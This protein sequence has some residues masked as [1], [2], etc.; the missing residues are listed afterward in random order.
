[1]RYRVAAALLFCVALSRVGAQN[2]TA[3]LVG[4]VT[5]PSGSVVAGAK[6]EIRN[7]ATNQVR[8]VQSDHKGEFT[9]PNLVA[10][11][12]E[13]TVHKEGFRTLR[14]TDLEL[15]LHQEARLELRLEVGAVS[16]TVEVTASLPQVNTENAAKGDVV[17]ADEMVQMPLIS[18]DFTDLAFLTPGVLPKA[19]GGESSSPMVINGARADNSNFVVDGFNARDPRDASPQV[20]PNLDSMQEFKLQTSGYSAETGRLA[21]GVM[22]MA[23]KTGGNRFHGSMFEFLRN[24]VFD[25]KNFFAASRLPLRRN[26]F[27]AALDG[28]V[29]IPKLYNGR[30][31]TFFLFSWESSRQR[32]RQPRLAVV[33]SEAER[34][35]DFSASP[36]IKDPLV[37]G[38]CNATNAAACFPDNR[39]PASRLSPV[40]LAVQEY[41][42]LPNR[43]GQVNNYY[44]DPPAPSDSD[45]FV[46]KIDQRVSQA[47]NVSLRYL[48]NY[49]RSLIPFGGGNTGLF[50]HSG[51]SHGTLAGLN[52]TRMFTPT[53]INEVR[54]SVS[55]T[56]GK[57]AG[58]HA[59]TDYNKLFGM[60]GGNHGS[61]AHR[62]SAVYD[63]QL[64]ELRRRRWMAERVRQHELQ[65]LRHDDPGERIA[66]AEGGSGHPAQPDVPA[67]C[68][69]YARN[70]LLHRCHDESALCRL[71]A[72]LA[73]FRYAAGHMGQKLSV[74]HQLQLLCPGRL[75]GYQPPDLES[76]PSL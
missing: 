2:P 38:V 59:G 8:S 70:L 24:D 43:P 9:A 44:A 62:L 32:Q 33:P 68:R 64:C 25:A 56:F 67:G 55:R 11:F 50:G 54:F 75:E 15:Q 3:T 30:N 51:Q 52:Y 76:G 23:L 60:S 10:G 61:L 46:V 26:Q 66:L 57:W 41:F 65:P 35:G 74:Y 48:K 4:T 22:T 39:I 18:R 63:H 36:R 6:L 13:I 49:N 20:H 1:M 28:P 27:G 21:G 19:E 58:V 53:V 72:G 12:Y 71:R 14:Q 42:P 37:S 17:V 29:L 45:N 16:Q 47:D 40:A 31:R 73:E 5:D 69:Q 34:Q 7:T